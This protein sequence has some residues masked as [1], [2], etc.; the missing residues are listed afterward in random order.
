[1]GGKLTLLTIDKSK[2]CSCGQNSSKICPNE[3]VAFE[4]IYLCYM[5]LFSLT[6]PKQKSSR[7]R[8]I[9][10]YI[11]KLVFTYEGHSIN[12]KN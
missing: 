3:S 5:K 10:N 11:S 2:K 6:F 12:K 1:M 9:D 4:S 7:L 8:H